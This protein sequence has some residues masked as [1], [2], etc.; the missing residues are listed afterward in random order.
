MP[1][2][3]QPCVMKAFKPRREMVG[4]IESITFYPLKSAKGIKI[5][6]VECLPS[7]LKLKDEDIYDR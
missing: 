2:Y 5:Y 3:I 1:R 6:T 7:G 4:E